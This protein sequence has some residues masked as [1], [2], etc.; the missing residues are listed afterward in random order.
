MVTNGQ[1]DAL[2]VKVNG[3]DMLEDV[4][5]QFLFAPQGLEK[6]ARNAMNH[7]LN[8]VRAEGVRTALDLKRAGDL[9]LRKR[10]TVAGWRT[11]LELRGLP[12]IGRA[13]RPRPAR[14]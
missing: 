7:A 8:A 4:K 5:R 1:G 12:C 14:P 6:A 3:L 10:L 9:W 13:M 11:A 2:E